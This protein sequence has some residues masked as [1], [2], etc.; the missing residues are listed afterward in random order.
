VYRDRPRDLSDPIAAKLGP[1]LRERGADVGGVTL[2][3]LM[4]GPLPELAEAVYR[5]E[6]SETEFRQQLL[7]DCLSR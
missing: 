1:C 7:V 6:S 4:Q 2:E 3:R 5:S